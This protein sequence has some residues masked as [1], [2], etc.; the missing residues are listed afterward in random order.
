MFFK[1]SLYPIRITGFLSLAWLFATTLAAQPSRITRQI[2][3]R[4][5]VTL[6]GHI[7]PKALPEFD[8]G[9]VAPSLALSY[10]TLTLG[11]S[12]AQKA[13]LDNLLV[14]Q[15]TPGSPNYHRWLTPEQFAQRFGPS[16]TDIAQITGWLQARGLRIT[17]V[18]KGRG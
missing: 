10:V 12:D 15:Q 2:D 8:Q 9:R 11:Q 6:R 17:S 5:R 13:A 16:D 18:A 4:D 3:D 1:S 14:E 7:H